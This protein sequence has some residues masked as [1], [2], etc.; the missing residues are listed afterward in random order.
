MGRLKNKLLAKILTKHP[1]LVKKF[2]EKIGEEGDPLKGVDLSSIPWTPVSKLLSESK[3]AIVTTAG[4]HLKDQTPFDMEDP[5]GD[6]TYREVPSDAPLDSYTITHDYYDH[7]D[8]DKDLN[9]VFPIERLR[10]LVAEG[11]IGSLA[12]SNFSFMGHIDGP[13]VGVLMEATAKEVAS[14]LNEDG[15]DIALLTP[16]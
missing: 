11:V 12:P 7:R 1:S 2:T 5:L 15:V 16:G 9:I 4:V 13:Y 8:A 6:P 3:V 14:K 10:E